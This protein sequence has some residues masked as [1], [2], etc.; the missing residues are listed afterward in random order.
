MP[1]CSAAGF[2]NVSRDRKRLKT[3]GPADGEP[4]EQ[5]AWTDRQQ[6]PEYL[7]YNGVK[8]ALT[9]QKNTDITASSQDRCGSPHHANQ[10]LVNL[11]V[12]VLQVTLGRSCGQR[13]ATAIGNSIEEKSSSSFSR[14][15][16]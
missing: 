4:D 6:P 11:A 10:L 13:S 2:E 5:S 1:E 8:T 7:A 9:F 16:T 15:K 14:D 12:R 3:K